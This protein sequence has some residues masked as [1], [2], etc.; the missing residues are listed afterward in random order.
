MADINLHGQHLSYLDRTA[1]KMSR[2]LGK[3]VSRRDVVEAL[4]EIAISDEEIYDPEYE[5]PTTSLRREIVQVER[6]SRTCKYSVEELLQVV[7][8]DRT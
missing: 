2:R 8:A 6:E 5:I 3:R 7:T 4:I 1:R